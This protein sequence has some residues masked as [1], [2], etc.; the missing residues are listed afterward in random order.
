LLDVEARGMS[1]NA[2]DVTLRASKHVVK[3]APTIGT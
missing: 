1:L 2:E 3:H